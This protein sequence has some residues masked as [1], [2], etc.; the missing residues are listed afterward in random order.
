MDLMDIE[1]K[2]IMEQGSVR[3]NREDY[4]YW[5][6]CPHCNKTMFGT[7]SIKAL[8]ADAVCNHCEKQVYGTPVWRN[9]VGYEIWE[10]EVSKIS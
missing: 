2:T 4:L 3:I 5:Y 10:K 8:H 6:Q 7:M 1:N 9:T